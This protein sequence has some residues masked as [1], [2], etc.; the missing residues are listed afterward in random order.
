MRQET[1]VAN[2]MIGNQ[3]F[4]TTFTKDVYMDRDD[5][6]DAIKTDKGLALMLDKINKAEDLD[7]RTSARQ[8]FLKDGEA[9]AAK[10]LED[11]VKA[12]IKQ[13]EKAGKPITYEAARKKVIV[14]NES[15]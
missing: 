13:R 6:L 8:E 1:V 4:E 10:S 15:D 14:M 2:I 9:A 5:I 11:Q 3:K 12:F 7:K